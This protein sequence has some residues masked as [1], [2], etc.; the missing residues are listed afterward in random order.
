MRIVRCFFLAA[1]CIPAF[2]QGDPALNNLLQKRL[3]G[4]KLFPAPGQFKVPGPADAGS[5]VPPKYCAI[6]LLN[7]IPL[8][9]IPLNATPLNTGPLNR[10]PA[11]ESF[12]MPVFKP[13]RET[14]EPLVNVPAPACDEKLF[15]NK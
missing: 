12:P 11:P 1:L 13:Q 2:G 8:N 14:R 5:K 4:M 3:E 10:K 9:A 6:P 7:A 15:R